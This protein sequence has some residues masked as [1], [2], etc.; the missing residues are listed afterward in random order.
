MRRRMKILQPAMCRIAGGRYGDVAMGDGHA[1]EGGAEGRIVR[2]YKNVRRRGLAVASSL[3][4]RIVI[5][6]AL[7][8]VR[9]EAR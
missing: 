3:C 5:L 9:Q 4:T 8:A 6:I 7:A 2:C 1:G